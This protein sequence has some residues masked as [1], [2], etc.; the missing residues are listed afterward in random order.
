MADVHLKTGG[1]AI[2]AKNNKSSFWWPARAADNAYFDVSISP[3][4]DSL[5]AVITP[6]IE[7][8]R[9]RALFTT[10]PIRLS[11]KPYF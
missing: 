4:V 1:Y 8:K 5:T 2:A 3:V 10:I 7:V 9:E 11:T 6:L